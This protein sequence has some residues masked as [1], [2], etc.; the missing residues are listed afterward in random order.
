MLF[1]SFALLLLGFYVLYTFFKGLFCV[2]WSNNEKYEQN[3][4]VL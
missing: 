2:D 1:C 3:N 4:G